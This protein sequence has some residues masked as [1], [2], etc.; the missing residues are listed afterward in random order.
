MLL[1]ALVQVR[2][3]E[4]GERPRACPGDDLSGTG[5][6]RSLQQAAL[7]F[8]KAITAMSVTTRLTDRAE[9]SCKLHLATIFDVLLA[10]SR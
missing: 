3:G 2:H 10:A 5:A 1:G 6:G 8:G 4:V 7:P 9:V